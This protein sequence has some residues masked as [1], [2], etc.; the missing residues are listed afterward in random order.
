MSEHALP[1]HPH[2]FIVTWTSF[3][4]NRVGVGKDFRRKCRLYRIRRSVIPHGI[5][6]IILSWGMAGLPTS[7]SNVL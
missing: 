3:D 2:S 5:A 4:D 1:P 7:G 6:V